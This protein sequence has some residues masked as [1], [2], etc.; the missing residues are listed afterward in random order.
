MTSTRAAA[1][2]RNG[3]SV[4]TVIATAAEGIPAVAAT[5]VRGNTD[6]RVLILRTPST[7][8]AAARAP[9]TPQARSSGLS[10]RP[11]AGAGA[12]TSAASKAAVHATPATVATTHVRAVATM[13]TKA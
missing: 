3:S 2:T 12:P 4:A 8:I 7:T 13:A 10:R 1:T 6:I 5:A 9:L 11:S